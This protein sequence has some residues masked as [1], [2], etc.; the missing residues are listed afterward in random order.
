MQ[1]IRRYG[2]A[3]IHFSVSTTRIIGSATDA[4]PNINGAI[5]YVL[6]LMALRVICFTCS[7]L[8]CTEANVG[9]K[10]LSMELFTF[11]IIKSG[12]CLPLL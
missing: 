1:K 3:G 6:S 11:E 5:I 4:N 7:L 10:T 2:N 9:N 12:N 8:S